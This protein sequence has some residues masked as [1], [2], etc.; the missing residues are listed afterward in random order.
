MSSLSAWLWS[1]FAV[2]ETYHRTANGDAYSQILGPAWSCPEDL[3]DFVVRYPNRHQ[4][5]AMLAQPGIYTPRLLDR[6]RRA[7]AE[8]PALLAQAVEN[9]WLE[10]DT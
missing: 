8:Y 7:L 6:A 10:K 2:P 3:C 4:I 5:E 1:W 9:G